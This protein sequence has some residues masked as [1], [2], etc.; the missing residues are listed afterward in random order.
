VCEHQHSH[1]TFLIL[2]TGKSIMN[3]L[4][5]DVHKLWNFTSVQLKLEKPSLAGHLVILHLCSLHHLLQ[6]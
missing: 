3:V 1:R 2:V 4:V 5:E 6:I